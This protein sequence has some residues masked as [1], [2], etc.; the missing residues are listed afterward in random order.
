L[1]GFGSSLGAR[2]SLYNPAQAAHAIK[3]MPS[4][5]QMASRKSII[6]NITLSMVVTEISSAYPQ[7]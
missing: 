3:N 6:Q 5:K 1:D 2:C 7:T 4:P